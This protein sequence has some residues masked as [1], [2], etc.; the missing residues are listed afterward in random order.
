MNR[1]RVAYYGTHGVPGH[2]FASIVGFFSEQE[3]RDIEKLDGLLQKNFGRKIEFRF[4]KYLDYLG[5]AANVSPDDKRGDCITVV[6]VEG[7]TD[8]NEVLDIIN[9]R[10]FLKDKFDRIREKYDIDISTVFICQKY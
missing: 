5:L 1:K 2:H 4:F 10:P 8:R 7:A 3:Q 6:L 9:N